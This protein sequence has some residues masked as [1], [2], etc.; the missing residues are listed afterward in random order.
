MKKVNNLHLQ[1]VVMRLRKVCSHLFL[2]QWPLDS[3]TCL[4]VVDELL[5]DAS[6]KMMVLEWLLDA[7]FARGHKV[8]MFSQFATMFDIIEVAILIPQ[9]LIYSR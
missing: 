2:S 5:V 9:H 1:N 6:G 4:P 3:P 8:L 7:L